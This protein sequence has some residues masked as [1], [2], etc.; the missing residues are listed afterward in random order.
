MI[1]EVKL[2][3][4]KDSYPFEGDDN[5]FSDM[6]YYEL[7][8]CIDAYIIDYENENNYQGDSWYLFKKDNKY[9]YLVFGWGSCSA[10]DMLQGCYQ[11]NQ[12]IE[13]LNDLDARIVWK[14][15][16][17]MLEYFETKD[18]I[19]EYYGE[20]PEFIAFKNRVIKYLKSVE[21]N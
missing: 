5:I 2:Y 18:W 17:D 14:S 19:L 15:K 20:L 4:L 16:E 1:D 10:C 9:G 3:K 12:V 8:Y 21:N 7:L 6:S 11:F 13:L